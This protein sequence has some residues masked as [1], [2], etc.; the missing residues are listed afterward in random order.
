MFHTLTY[1]RVAGLCR[2]RLIER[3]NAAY[4][5]GIVP[6]RLCPSEE[7]QKREEEQERE[8]LVVVMKEP[9]PNLLMV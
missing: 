7:A 1:M 4:P 9:K 3:R 5:Q 2:T 8:Q 6:Q